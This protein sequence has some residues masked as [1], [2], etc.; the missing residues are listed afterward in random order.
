[1]YISNI[2]NTNK[3]YY[4]CGKVIGNYLIKAG[5]PMLSNKDGIMIFA[6][7]K[8]LQKAINEMPFLLQLLV[9]GGVING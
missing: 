1:M 2:D 6:K 8:K 5:I 4:E 3:K 9:K 7:T